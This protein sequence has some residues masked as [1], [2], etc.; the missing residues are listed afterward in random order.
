MLDVFSDESVASREHGHVMFY[1]CDSC[2]SS[3]RIPAPPTL[4]EFEPAAS[5]SETAATSIPAADAMHLDE[6]LKTRSAPLARLPPLFAR[7]A[8][9]V[10]YCGNNTL[11]AREPQCGDGI[12]IT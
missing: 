3:R 5:T 1:R 2:N 7:E 6:P 9:H 8:G 11:L 10:V 4:V 12:Y